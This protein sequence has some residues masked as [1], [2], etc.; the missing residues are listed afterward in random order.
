M[1]RN[2]NLK[3]NCVCVAVKRR[4]GSFAIG[5]LILLVAASGFAATQAGAPQAPIISL[6]TSALDFGT[7]L[8]GTT[9]LNQKV[10]VTNVGNAVLRIQA[11]FG[12]DPINFALMRGCPATLAPGQNCNFSVDFSPSQAGTI[13]AAVTIKDN[14]PGNP[15]MVSLTGIGVMPNVHL[16]ATSLDFG[17][18]AV[19]S[20]GSAQTVSLTNS[21]S[22]DLTNIS[23]SSNSGEFAQTNDCP[24]TLAPSASCTIAATFAPGSGAT[25]TATL[26]I[27]DSD[28]SSPQ[29]VGMTGTGAAGAVSLSPAILAFPRQ[30]INTTSLAKTATLTNTG[31]ASL[32]MVSIIASGDFAQ[33]NTC[34]PSL[35][36]GATC[37]IRVTFTPSS[38]GPRAGFVTF[39]DT[40][41]T[42]LQ[43]LNLTGTGV[44]TVS[45]ISVKPRAASVNFTATQQY[46]AF[47]NNI[48]TTD[49]TWAVDGITGGNSTVG[50][51][52]T[53]GLYTPPA[54]AGS[55][56]VTATSNSQPSQAAT[57]PIV[58]TNFAGAF[59]YHYDN[60][61]IGLNSNETVLT[62]GN[63]NK[64]QFGKVFSYPVDGRIY[65]EPLYVPSVNIPGQGVHNV[66]YVTTEHDSVYAFDAD[67][68]VPGPLWQASFI[69]PANGIT[70]IPA[71]DIFPVGICSSIGPEIGTTGTPVID[72]ATGI[73]YLLV[74]TKEVVGGVAS[75][76]QRLHAIDI[77]TGNEVSGSPRLI[78][79]TVPGFGEGN[80]Q[81]TIS[82]D[83]VRHNSRA[84]LLLLNG[85]V[86]VVWA[87]PCD[88]HPYHGWVLGYDAN[89]LQ[90]VSVYNTSPNGNAD[91]IWQGGAGI[92]AD[93][94]GNIFFATGNGNFTVDSGGTDYG[95]AFMK[96]S[97][98][99][100]TLGVA[101]Y[102]VPYNQQ[103]LVIEDSDLSG[104]GPLLLPDQPTSPTHLLVGAGKEGTVYLIDRDNMGQFS[105]Y[106]NNRIQQTL[107]AAVGIKGHEDAYFGIPAYW[108]NHLY[109]WGANDVLKVFRLHN[110][111]LSQKPI[112]SATAISQVPGPVP[113][114]S[115]NA[116]TNGIVWT[117]HHRVNQPTILR[118]Y[119]AAN[120]SREIYDS[121]Q[122]GTR[123]QA[124]ISVRFSL[125]TVANG[126]VYVGTETELDVYGLLP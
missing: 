77:T 9:S 12:N 111:L 123:D 83:E 59:T 25:R 90:Q 57:V 114:V 44:A 61:R 64:R 112:A 74:R 98:A 78:Q 117:M 91:S 94:S 40:D 21:G 116:N 16:S 73:L 102:F 75:Y 33:Q 8:F 95:D 62:T 14:A 65:A 31:S 34:P 17:T 49:V 104:G 32:E 30:R 54:V 82:F 70:T 56:S 103:D 81:G 43:T 93:T 80:V 4:S 37:T 85:V 124:G 13:N 29:L 121:A 36:P 52:S 58:I 69:D 48:F 53:A 41:P 107:V 18:V 101:D 11:I 39:S 15:H 7:Q 97:T 1:I 50:T 110:G 51:I 122:M 20:T 96:L 45:A 125:P 28:S 76:P 87:S 105:P 113:T 109:F 119:D 99:N 67:G 6:S 46:Q 86:Y 79:A 47:L 60:A 5:I 126:R 115:S 35:A 72:S 106:D 92:A 66:V 3:S 23:V 24:G 38:T 22:T 118:A 108:Q 27:S 10:T 89:T 88:Q 71:G 68:L 19:G 2:R 120:I 63:V 100:G 42:S 55:H 84:G 26:T